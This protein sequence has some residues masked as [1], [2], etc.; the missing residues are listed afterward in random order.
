MRLFL[1]NDRILFMFFLAI[2]PTF[3]NF[4]KFLQTG[5][6]LIQCLHGDMEAFMNKLTSKFIKPEI[7]HKFAGLDINLEN[8]KYD[9]N[10]TIGSITK[11]KLCKA[12]DEVDISQSNGDKFF[13]AVR[14]FL[15]TAH[16][17]CVKWLP[18]HY[19]LYTVIR[20]TL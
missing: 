11:A 2:L 9:K 15:E 18:L 10:L 17:Y 16:T 8:Q 20:Y 6:P 4:N 14:E 19:P 12:L 1:K 5:E 3:T 13:N 7:I